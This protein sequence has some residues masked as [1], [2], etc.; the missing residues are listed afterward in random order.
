MSLAEG[1][2]GCDKREAVS[3]ALNQCNEAITLQEAKKKGLNTFKGKDLKF[4]GKLIPL[5]GVTASLF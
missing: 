1:S 2:G 4:R 3:N 5:P